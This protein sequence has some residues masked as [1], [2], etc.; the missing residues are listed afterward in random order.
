MPLFAV[1]TYDWYIKG[2]GPHH[3]QGRRGKD[4]WENE[5]ADKVVFILE[6][7][8][9]KPDLS[10]IGWRCVPITLGTLDIPTMKTPNFNH[11]VGAKRLHL[12]IGAPSLSEGV[13]MN[14]LL[15]SPLLLPPWVVLQ[16]VW[17]IG[18]G[19]M[20]ILLVCFAF[21]F[22]CLFSWFI[23]H[24]F[25]LVGSAWASWRDCNLGWQLA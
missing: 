25:G 11:T 20:G 15:C 21:F 16:L 2:A 17:R 24:N 19:N 18:R 12:C 23:P 22:F 8:L 9:V 3:P 5:K 6:S 7:S 4:I 1:Q 14:K 13:L 10:H